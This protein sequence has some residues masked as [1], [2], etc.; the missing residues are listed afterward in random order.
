MLLTCIYLAASGVFPLQNTYAPSAAPV[1]VASAAP[2]NVPSAA[3]DALA[4]AAPAQNKDDHSAQD[5][6]AV[7]QVGVGIF[8]Q[9][10]D[11]EGFVFVKSMVPGGSAARDGT[12]Q[13]GDRI[14]SVDDR[15]VAGESLAAIKSL[16][17]GPQGSAVKMQF[18]RQSSNG[19]AQDVVVSLIRS[20]PAPSVTAASPVSDNPEI[21]MENH[22]KKFKEFTSGKYMTIK[23]LAKSRSEVEVEKFCDFFDGIAN[24]EMWCSANGSA[25]FDA[26]SPSLPPL[27][28]AAQAGDVSAILSLTK[29]DKSKSF[30]N[31]TDR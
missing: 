20:A 13:V 27:C 16:I 1:D 23:D 8:F 2:V 31:Q 25:F 14:L 7:A 15:S 28:S 22:K 12:V 17:L 19:E 30:L 3:P 26:E 6:H 5:A 11:D 9:M 29:D 4:P 10:N 18:S 21:Q 24:E